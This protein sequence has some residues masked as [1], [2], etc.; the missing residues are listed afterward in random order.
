[1]KILLIGG[2]GFIG[3]HLIDKL[4]LE[5]HNVRVFDIAFERFR[6]P[7]APVDYRISSTL[8]LAE[9]YEAML[10]IDMIFHLASSSVPST[11][12]VDVV[13][14]VNQNLIFSLNVLDFA[15]KLNIN[16]FVYLSS[17]GAVYG[18][19]EV[20]K[21]PESHPLNPI[22]SYGIVKCTIERYLSLYQRLHGLNTIILRPSNPYGPRQGH[23]IAQG[24]IST[25]LKNIRTNSEIVVFGDGFTSKDYIYI[26]DLVNI[27]Y[28]ISVSE[29]TGIYNIGSGEGT[30]LNE[31]I[32]IIEKVTGKK[33]NISKQP[34]RSYD[35]S[36]FILDTTKI[37]EHQ[38]HKPLISLESGIEKVWKWLSDI[39]QENGIEK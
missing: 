35:V 26:D 33:A 1:M 13:N 30:S 18:I 29:R 11:S 6:K 36:N 22:S 17:G 7:L 3:S 24:V 10:D 15:V 12:G 39:E 14:E 32:S 28:N 8:S 27:I 16:K 21:I 37:L 34:R 25:F 31:I 38:N 23:F 2:N 19:P 4:I 5:G 9:L 20:E